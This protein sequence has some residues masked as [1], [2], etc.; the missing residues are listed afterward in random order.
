MTS[1]VRY[2]RCTGFLP[3]VNHVTSTAVDQKSSAAC[4]V[5]EG[6]AVRSGAQIPMITELG[7]ITNDLFQ[8]RLVLVIY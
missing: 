4:V 8:S 7:Q 3:Q 5:G 6:R 1:Q 2:W